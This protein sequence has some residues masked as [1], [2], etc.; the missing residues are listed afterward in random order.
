[1]LLPKMKNQKVNKEYKLR[2]ER[3]YFA[4]MYLM[5]TAKLLLTYIIIRILFSVGKVFFF[6]ISIISNNYLFSLAHFIK[7]LSLL[8]LFIYF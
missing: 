2:L 4:L 8:R 7:D 3:N 6:H 5:L 1:M